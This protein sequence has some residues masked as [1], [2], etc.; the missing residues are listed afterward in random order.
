MRFLEF[1]PGIESIELTVPIA[2][3][4][5]EEADEFFLALLESN[6]PNVIVDADA[7][8]ASITILDEDRESYYNEG[9]KNIKIWYIV[10]SF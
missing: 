2:N 1:M 8:N 5:I 7:S 4:D 3:D 10:P 6:Q 9:T